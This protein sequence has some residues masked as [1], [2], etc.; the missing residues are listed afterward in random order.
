MN[1][2][3]G[4]D[5]GG[6]DL[7][8]LDLGGLTDNFDLNNLGSGS[9]FGVDIESF[10]SGGLRGFDTES[11]Q[12]TV[13]DTISQTVDNLGGGG[14]GGML[15]GTVTNMS[16]TTGYLPLILTIVVLSVVARFLKGAVKVVLCIIAV[17]FV[18]Y[19][20]HISN[21]VLPVLNNYIPG[22]IKYIGDATG[23]KLY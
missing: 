9:E 12:S 13:N 2:I 14:V 18:C 21:I 4:F 5:L 23:V 8:G 11:I 6:V 1:S 19:R 17:Y 10:V 7:S 3:G 15:G 22:V 16:V 20:T